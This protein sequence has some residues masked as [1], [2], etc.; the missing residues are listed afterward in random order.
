MEQAFNQKSLCRKSGCRIPDLGFSL[1]EIV[2]AIGIISFALLAIISLF[3]VGLQGSRESSE[4]TYLALMTQYVN[5]W[6]RSQAFANLAAASNNASANPAPAFFFNAAGEVTRDT[7]GTPVP[8]AAADSHYACTVTWQ[9]SSVSTNLI[10]LQY[11]FEWPWSAPAA[12]RQ[13]RVIVT[14]RA[15]EE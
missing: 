6:S 7:G 13:Q 8:V 5:A 9:T 15:N 1:V 12:G 4:D 3:S 14:S 10:S 11:R 2:M